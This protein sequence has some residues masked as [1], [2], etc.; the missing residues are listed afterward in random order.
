[1]IWVDDTVNQ[2]LLRIVAKNFPETHTD[3]Y[4]LMVVFDPTRATQV[5]RGRNEGMNFGNVYVK[6]GTAGDGDHGSDGGT[7]RT[8][9]CWRWG[10]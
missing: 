7:G 3:M 8:F 5:S 4:G 1:M 2:K 9:E 6:S 10:R